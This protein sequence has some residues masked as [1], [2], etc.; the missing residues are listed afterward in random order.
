MAFWVGAIAFLAVSWALRRGPRQVDRVFADRLVISF[1]GAVSAGKSSGIKATFGVN[2]GNIHPIPGTTKRVRV[3][4]LPE[5]LSVADTPGMQDPDEQ[6]VRLAKSFIDNTDIFVHVINSNPGITQKVK[7]DM[8]VLRATCRP[9]LVV[10]NKIDTISE[11]VRAG[12]VLHQQKI[13]DVAPEM[14]FSVAFDPLPQVSGT[15]MSVEPLRERIRQVVERQGAQL[16]REK[17]R[18]RMVQRAEKQRST[19]ASAA[20]IMME[21][22]LDHGNRKCQNV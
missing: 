10:L 8:A 1:F 11:G 22:L 18:A 21:R 16:V 4:A 14:F 2:P 7:A 5:G 17:R 12:F 13:A 15:P 6:R 19:L 3:W 20:S 9:V